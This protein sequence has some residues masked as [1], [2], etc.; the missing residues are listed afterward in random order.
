MLS[1]MYMLY[2]EYAK[3]EEDKHSVSR[4]AALLAA[5][6]N[7]DLED[8]EEFEIEGTAGKYFRIKQNMLTRICCTMTK[9]QVF[10]ERMAGLIPE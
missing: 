2:L 4:R 5:A 1:P 8:T 3:E 6:P 9:F 7:L 10:V